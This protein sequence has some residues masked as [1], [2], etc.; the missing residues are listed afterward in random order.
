MIL[1]FSNEFYFS[2]G[3]VKCLWFGCITQ[4]KQSDFFLTLIPNTLKQLLDIISVYTDFNIN[5][6]III[7]NKIN[8]L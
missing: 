5:L 2:K 4:L 7:F 1:N 6:Q 8:S 3:N